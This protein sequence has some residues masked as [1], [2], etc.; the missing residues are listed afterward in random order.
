M[1]RPAH[2]AYQGHI[3]GGQLDSKKPDSP[4]T[5]DRLLSL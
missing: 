4:V 3:D 5:F 1:P 2:T